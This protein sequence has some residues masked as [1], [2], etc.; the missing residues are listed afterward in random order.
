MKLPEQVRRLGLVVGVLVLAIVVVRFVVVPRSLVARDFHRASTVAREAAKPVKHAGSDTCVN[1]HE[2]VG[3]KKAKSYHRGLACETCHGPAVGHA[4]DPGSA[5]PPAP[6]DRK[7]CPVCHAYDPARPTGFPQINP[8]THNPTVACITCHNPHDPV[9][10]AVPA[11]CA[12]CH[13]QIA[14]TKSVSAHAK[15]E[16]TVCHQAP[17]QHKILPRTARPT[18]P[19]T[20]EVCG[21]CHGTTAA[22]KDTPKVDLAGHGG[23]FLCWECHYPHLPEGRG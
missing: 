20:R 19:T 22:R 10:P 5:K 21:T 6:R 14:F 9:P 1:C 16:C 2:D 18:K 17:Q 8:V 13:Q 11:E 3:I 23:R 7:F 15:V 4:E 12:A